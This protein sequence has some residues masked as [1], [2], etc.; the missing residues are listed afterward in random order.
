MSETVQSHPLA[1]EDVVEAAK[2]HARKASAGLLAGLWGY[3]P[4]FSLSSSRADTD[5]IMASQQGPGLLSLAT[6]IKRCA[7]ICP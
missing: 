3:L 1:V 6:I 2:G 5:E 4:V 7:L